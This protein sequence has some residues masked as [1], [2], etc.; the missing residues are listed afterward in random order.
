MLGQEHILLGYASSISYYT[1][2][3]VVNST[4]LS[5]YGEKVA[6]D[7]QYFFGKLV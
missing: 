1:R 6:N 5:A 2:I 3:Y 4:C 7:A